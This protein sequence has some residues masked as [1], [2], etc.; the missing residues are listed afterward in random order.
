MTY[1]GI[2][3]SLSST[4][5]CIEKT[6]QP[7]QYFNFTTN[8]KRSKWHN[9]V[10]SVCKFIDVYYPE[11]SDYSKN[12]I[13]KNIEYDKVAAKIVALI[14]DTIDGDTHIAIEGYSYS[15]N[16]GPLI[17][18]VTLST[19]IR[20]RI[21]LLASCK[22]EIKSFTIVQPSVLK[23]TTCRLA[24]NKQIKRNSKMIYVNNDDIAG[25]SF[26]KTQM[27][28]A[29]L[30]DSQDGN[31]SLANVIISF[32]DEL[33]N[34][35]AIPKPIDDITDAFWLKELAKREYANI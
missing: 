5:I 6:E 19:F 26:K 12:E 16:A 18:L 23:S 22:P 31:S 1:I 21:L 13:S 24:Y 17:D 7:D 3:P 20:H 11:Y 32:K 33:L 14:S 2:D 35:K 8:S 29:M 4:A 27:L 25:G 30:E 9:L 15:S 34:A 28:K 10:S